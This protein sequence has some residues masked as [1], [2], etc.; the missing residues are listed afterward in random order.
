METVEVE[1]L[2]PPWMVIVLVL[3][4]EPSVM[5]DVPV[6]LAPML[7][8]CVPELPITLPMLMVLL[9]LAVDVWPMVMVPV[10]LAPPKVMVPVVIALPIATEPAF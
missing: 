6:A 3:E 1:P 7:M 8:V 2:T 5:L 10:W 9:V 4:V